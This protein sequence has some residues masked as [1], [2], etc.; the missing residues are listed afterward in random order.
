M[1]QAI[2]DILPFAVGVA[3]CPLPIIAVIA[4]LVSAKAGTNSLAF[5]AGWVVGVA[6][7]SVVLLAVAGQ[8]DSESSG[9]SST[10]S[11]TIKVLLG[12][13][14][15]FLAARNYRS[16]PKAGEEPELPAW[17]HRIDALSPTRVAGLGVLLSA[18]NPKSLLL[19]AGAMLAVSQYALSTGDEVVVV[20][21]FVL[22]SISTVAA[23]VIMYRVA[24]EKAHQR[25]DEMKV[26]LT[27]NNAVVMAVLLLIIGVVLI[28]QGTGDLST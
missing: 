15:V 13:A 19:I 12:V 2:G 28:G 18:L 25:L 24:G 4:T 3:V 22:V 8:L 14:L 10:G 6:G 7:A 20:L 27:H 9:G 16:R 26:W 17:L 23:P 21:V 11:S 1:G 5:L